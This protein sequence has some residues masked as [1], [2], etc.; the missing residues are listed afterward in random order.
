MHGGS[1]RDG[2]GDGEWH[3]E[4][5]HAC[6]FPRFAV[7]SAGAA[8]R[9]VRPREGGTL[10]R[11]PAIRVGGKRKS[12]GCFTDEDAAGRAYDAAIRKYYPDEKPQRWKGYNFTAAD[13]EEGSDD[14]DDTRSARGA[15]S[16]SAAA[17][18]ESEEEE[19]EEDTSSSSEEHPRRRRRGKSPIDAEVLLFSAFL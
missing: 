11:R 2:A 15:A 10:G 4:H 17:I 13:G 12:L 18:D 14:G 9:L 6:A 19:E 16:S 5:V 1:E 7:G 3:A 8:G